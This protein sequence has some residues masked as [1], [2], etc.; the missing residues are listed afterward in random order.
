[1]H[2]HRIKY[3]VHVLHV[4]GVLLPIYIITMVPPAIM[5]VLNR[6][7]TR[8]LRTLFYIISP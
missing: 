8:C 1:M 6:L 2:V 4:V 7:I 3:L 5:T